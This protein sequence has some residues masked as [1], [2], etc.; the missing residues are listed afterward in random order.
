MNSKKQTHIPY[1][2]V[3][4][5]AMIVVGVI[6]EVTKLSVNSAMQWLGMIVFL[7]G[8]IL[9]AQAFSKTNDADI[10]FG[11]AFGSGFKATAIISIVMFAWS[12]IVLMI[13]PGI[14]DRGLEKAHTEMTKN[15]KMSEEQIDMAMSYT[16]KYFKVLMHAG[17]LFGTLIFGVIAS[18]IAAAFAKKV[19]SRQPV[20]Q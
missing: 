12:F 2:S 7:T 15:P 5:L 6:L 10:T 19:P 11:Q 9:N 17:S 16:K 18:L 14:Y 20:I 8:I 13:F 4:A 1:G 3:T